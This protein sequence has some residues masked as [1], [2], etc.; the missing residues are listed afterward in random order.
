MNINKLNFLIQIVY[1]LHLFYFIKSSSK[2]TNTENQI[3]LNL[4]SLLNKDVSLIAKNKNIILPKNLKN[5]ANLNMMLETIQSNPK[6]Q[7]YF[8][9]SLPK[10][11]TKSGQLCD[12]PFEYQGIKFYDKC[13][14]REDNKF[15]CKINLK[16]L[17]EKYAIIKK[18]VFIVDC[19]FHI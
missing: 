16:N 4:E 13:A 10:I 8:L 6:S 15:Y 1:L 9:P 11:V 7:N 18:E 17:S 19:S 2:S 5:N 3:G 14:M 12:F